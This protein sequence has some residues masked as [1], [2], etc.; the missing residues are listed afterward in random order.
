MSV[1]YKEW[2]QEGNENS[3]VSPESPT[4]IAIGRAVFGN[5]AY[6]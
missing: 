2:I 3:V 1:L 4:G 6:G 5:K